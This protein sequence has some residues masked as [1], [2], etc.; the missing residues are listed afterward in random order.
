MCVIHCQVSFFSRV[1]NWSID[2][3]AFG[4]GELQDEWRRKMD[5]LMGS[6]RLDGVTY[7]IAQVM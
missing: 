7:Q 6:P 3:F 1:F 5:P 2:Y 4:I